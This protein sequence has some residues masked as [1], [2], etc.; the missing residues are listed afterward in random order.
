MH[1]SFFL[2]IMDLAKNL[3]YEFVCFMIILSANMNNS[4][5]LNIID[6]PQGIRQGVIC[7]SFPWN[8]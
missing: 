1:C 3:F 8:V 5:L 6:I 2:K 4:F 7:L